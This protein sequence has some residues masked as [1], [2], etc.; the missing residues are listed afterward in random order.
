[1]GNF[2]ATLGASVAAAAVT[3][4]MASTPAAANTVFGSDWTVPTSVAMNAIPSN[5]PSRTPDMTFTAPTPLDFNS[6]TLSNGYTPG[7]FVATAGGTVLTGTP[8]YLASSLDSNLFEFTGTVTVTT[9]QKFKAGHDDGLT[10]TIGGTTVISAPGATAFMLT[11]DTYTGPSGNFPFQLVYGECCGPPAILQIDLPF[12]SV[13]PEPASLALLGTALAG[14]GAVIR[15][16][17][18]TG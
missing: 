7:G 4:V 9:G 6:N 2:K 11:T 14:I 16:R 5:V 18:K 1:M 13:V 15:R 10:L 17:R 12:T 8:A 3:A